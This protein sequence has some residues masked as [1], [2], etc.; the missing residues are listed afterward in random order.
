MTATAPPEITVGT[1]ASIEVNLTRSGPLAAVGPITLSIDAQPGLSAALVVVP[2]DSSTGKIDV[3]VSADRKHGDYDIVVKATGES[4]KKSDAKAKTVFRGLAGQLDTGFGTDG[5]FSFDRPNS[6]VTG[7][8]VQSD[9]KIVLGGRSGGELAFLQLT[10]EGTLIQAFN[11]GATTI[12]P[13]GL[14]VLRTAE[15]VVDKNDSV[16]MLY[17]IST[18]GDP[19]AAILR[20]TRDGALDNTFGSSG[21]SKVDVLVPGSLAIAP[22]GALFVGGK[23]P[24]DAT[25]QYVTKLTPAGARDMT[26]GGGTGF[27]FA[28]GP[29]T[30]LGTPATSCRTWSVIVEPGGTIL[31]CSNRNDGGF[32][33]RIKADG[34]AGN[35]E[36]F[37]SLLVDVCRSVASHPT[38]DYAYVG[39]D[40]GTTGQVRRVVATGAT[41]GPYGNSNGTFDAAPNT[42]KR[43]KRIANVNGKLIVAGDDADG[44]FGVARLTPLGA[45]D[46]SFGGTGYIKF[47]IAGRNATVSSLALD[48]RG[49]VVIGGSD[50]GLVAARIWL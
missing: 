43:V 20:L 31:A 2:A 37:T 27:F 12:K 22:D 1:Q 19:E 46:T 42:L 11:G 35:L 32:V 50:G 26:W 16:A 9:G 3:V 39:G 23:N 8:V 5:T 7:V 10:N 47:K 15:L 24:S 40:T 44:G 45:L 29:G 13:P 4:G 48:S 41:D 28:G 25:G 30:C 17:E 49:R 34:T 18:N 21:V 36:A 14:Q 38:Q 33:H 6:D